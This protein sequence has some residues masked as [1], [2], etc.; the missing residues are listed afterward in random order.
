MLE[1]TTF[2]VDFDSALATRETLDDLAAL[3]LDDHPERETVYAELEALTA[4]G[5]TG[6]MPFGDSLTA[7][8]ALLE[9][10]AHRDHIEELNE[11]LAD[12][13][14]PSAVAHSDWFAAN[15]ERLYVISGG[16]EEIIIP[17]VARVGILAT[18]VYANKFVFDDNGYIV[19]HD[20][21]RLT[22]Q[23]GGKAAQAAKLK[24]AGRA[25]AV[26]DGYTDLEIREQGVA[27]EFWAIIETVE[28]PNVTTRA[29]RIISDFSE[30]ALSSP[31]N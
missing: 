30:L 25:V 17:T 7:R 16:F 31:A 12:Q 9:G 24:V 6:A 28:R 4:L 3:A 27:D 2:F 5:M 15:A 13:L 18:H 8:L 23:A 22:A 14:S 21:N 20:T 29:D 19:G 26:G 11:Q 10:I 1:Q